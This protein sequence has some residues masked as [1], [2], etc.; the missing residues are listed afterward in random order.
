VTPD[1]DLLDNDSVVVEG[2][3]FAPD[4]FVS[5]LQ[6]ANPVDQFGSNCRFTAAGV[7]ASPT[8]TFT[9]SITVKRLVIVQ[10]SAVD[11]ADPGACVVVA[12]SGS[13]DDSATAPIAFDGSVPLPPPPTMT[14]TPNTDLVDGDVVHVTGAGFTPSSPVAVIQCQETSGPD[15]SG[16]NT[17]D[18]QTVQTDATGAMS[19]D[20]TV[21]RIL[22]LGNTT[23]DCA[24]QTCRIVLAE[25]PFGYPNVSADIAFDP[26][27]P[28][29]PPPTLVAEPSTDLVDGQT[30]T[31]NGSGYPRNRSLG[32]A[33]CLTGDQS[34]SGCDLQHYKFVQTDETGSFTTTFT[35]YATYQSDQGPV[36]CVAV[37]GHCRIGAGTAPGGIGADAL[38][39][40]ATT[41]P[42]TPTTTE[43]AATA[44]EAVAVEPA[45]TG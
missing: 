31:V 37:P 26:S 24:T 25:L 30:V 22:Y 19:T 33:Q 13:L 9:L 20:F 39:S 42:T 2:Q 44:V 45:F 18:F 29:P 1:T 28:P 6:C 5:V 14:A 40:F 32:M 27:V 38:L 7:Q 17:S 4:Q 35:V 11:C 12:A 23:V 34:P 3:D 21:D 36:D 16:C 43:P 10:G 15:G 8:G 41:T